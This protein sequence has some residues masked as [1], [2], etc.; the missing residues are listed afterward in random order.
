MFQT[1]LDNLVQTIDERVDNAATRQKTR[2]DIG[3]ISDDEKLII[4]KQELYRT[5]RNGEPTADLRRAIDCIQEGLDAQSKERHSFNSQL[6]GISNSLIL[7]AALAIG[8]SYLISGNCSNKS[9][10]L[11]RDARMIPNAISDYLA[12]KPEAKQVEKMQKE[13]F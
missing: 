13:D 9:S 7:I 10:Q 4:L 1:I 11:C 12:D 8:L 2:E 3:F 5:A 6:S